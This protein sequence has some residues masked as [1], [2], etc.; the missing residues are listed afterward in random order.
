MKEPAF[1]RKIFNRRYDSLS[2][3]PN[4]KYFVNNLKLS[5]KSGTILKKWNFDTEDCI[6]HTMKKREELSII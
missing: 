2:P 6:I 4:F 1:M 3:T 5:L